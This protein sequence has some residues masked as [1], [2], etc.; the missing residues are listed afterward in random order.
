MLEFIKKLFRRPIL[1]RQ[2]PEPE[3]AH[4]TPF[5]FS[6]IA[7]CG[8]EDPELRCADPLSFLGITWACGDC[9]GRAR[10]AVINKIALS[11]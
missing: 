9:R 10:R 5:G 6:G 4:W 2:K 1:I 8:A 7:A 3:L 11:R